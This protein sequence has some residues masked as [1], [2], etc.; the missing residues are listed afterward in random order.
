TTIERGPVATMP[1]DQVDA[2]FSHLMWTNF[3]GPDREK[4]QDGAPSTQDG[5]GFLNKQHDPTGDVRLDERSYT[6]NLNQL[7][8]PDPILNTSDPLSANPYSYSRDNPVEFSDPS[9]LTHLP[10]G[11]QE[12][13]PHPHATPTH[14]CPVVLPRASASIPSSCGSSNDSG[15][16]NTGQQ[17]QQEEAEPVSSGSSSSSGSTSGGGGSDNGG[18]WE[19]TP[20][21]PPPPPPV[22]ESGGAGGL[23]GALGSALSGLGDAASNVAGAVSSGAQTWWDLQKATGSIIIHHPLEVG[24]IAGLTVLNGLQGGADPATDAAEGFLLADLGG[25]VLGELAIEEGAPE[26]EAGV[27]AEGEAA[28]GDAATACGN[29][30]SGDTRVLMAKHHSKAIRK[31]KAGD[32]VVATDPATGITKA[33]PVLA[34]IKHSGPHSMVLITFSDGSQF[35]ATVGHM[36]WDASVQ[37]FVAAGTVAIGHR[38][39]ARGTSYLTVRSKVPTHRNRWAYNLEVKSIHTYYVGPTPV[40]V[41]NSCFEFGGEAGAFSDEEL[42]QM[43]YQHAGEGDLAGRPTVEQILNAME[44]GIPTRIRSDAVRFD[45]GSVRVFINESLPWRSTAVVR[46]AP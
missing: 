39:L 12:L 14:G 16:H 4:T 21:P 24:G 41:H 43:A 27:S 37:R 28:E 31:I 45:L 33:E 20:L 8:T 6:P 26:V 23:L 17:T 36:I 32:Q 9:G 44:N 35:D 13:N 29:S 34:V 19:G 15:H 30:F 5:R 2:E 18:T 40:L 7:T 25:D 11:G 10:G 42:A 3:S 38:V 22:A 1:S 46:G